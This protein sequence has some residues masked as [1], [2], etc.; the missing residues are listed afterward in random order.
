MSE[1]SHIL[2]GWEDG[3]VPQRIVDRIQKKIDDLKKEGRIPQ[4][5]PYTAK[6]LLKNYHRE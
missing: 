3:N 4:D 6:D 2:N 1:I 5:Y